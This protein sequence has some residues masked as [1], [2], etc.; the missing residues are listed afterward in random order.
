LG[1]T[2]SHNNSEVK[3]RDL[4]SP[5]PDYPEE[6]D[7][8]N[9]EPD[10]VE[11]EWQL[12]Q[13]DCHK[14]DGGANGELVGAAQDLPGG[15]EII[16]RRYEFYKYVGPIDEETGEALADRVGPDGIHGVNE[17]TNTVIVGAYVGAQMS[18]FDVDA[19][20][21]LI[22]Q[23]EDGELGAPYTK[24]TVIIAGNA[25]FT[26]TTAGALPEGMIFDEGTGEISGTPTTTGI[27]FLTV[28]AS[29][30]NNPVISKTYAFAVTEP[31]VVLPPHSTVDT[32]AR[33]VTGGTT[34]GQGW[35]TNGTTATV[36]AAPAA[37]FAFVSWTDNGVQVSTT[38][39]YQFTNH[40]NRS[41]VANFVL[42]PQLTL[43]APQRN[44]LAFAWPTNFAGF[45]LQQS[46]D[47]M[48]TNWVRVTNAAR[49]VGGTYEILLGPPTSNTFFRLAR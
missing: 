12:L 1:V 37:G 18:A 6:A 39:T 32:S 43:A 19:P 36:T 49:V 23:L 28:Q 22:D 7:W 29:D 15:D 27:F 31:G 8:R 21:G 40:V 11:V 3:L 26:A 30:T 24:R 25:P 5:D 35:Y 14:A 9:G 44:V 4:V 47:L 17:Y 16:T 2:V 42:A 41:L 48:A 10:E 34:E 20:I 33:P 38:S 13:T 45:G 46:P